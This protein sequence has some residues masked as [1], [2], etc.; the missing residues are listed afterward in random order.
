MVVTPRVLNSDWCKIEAGAAWGLDKPIFAILR[1]VTPV[2]LPGPLS[3][4]QARVVETRQQQVEFI[5][6]LKAYFVADE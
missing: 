6:E 5:D 1:Y 3:T 2:E 4:L